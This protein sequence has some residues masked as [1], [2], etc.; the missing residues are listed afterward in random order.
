M[1][2]EDQVYWTAP[3]G[4]NA[5]FNFR[6][7]PSPLIVMLLL[8]VVPLIFRKSK[9]SM[10]KLVLPVVLF[11]TTSAFA[12]FEEG[13]ESFAAGDF[14]CVESEL[15]DPWPGGTAG[16]EW[17][18]PVSDDYSSEG[19]KSLKIE[20]A[21]VAGGPMDVIMNIGKTEGNWSLDWDMYVPEGNSAY[22]NV[23]GTDIA[24]ETTNSWQCNVLIYTDGSVIADGPWGVSELSYIPLGEWFN[25][26][27][28]VDLDQGIF[29]MWVDGEE[30]F[31]APYDGNFSSIN[32]YAL[33]DSETI[34]LYYL[35]NFTLA[36]SDVELVGV[37]D[38]AIVPFGFSP[39]PTSGT[40]NLSGVTASQNL[41]VLD[42]MGREV[43]RLPVEAGQKAVEVDLP[44]G[45]YLF[46][47][48]NG[49]SLR[50]L[51]VRR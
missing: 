33:G 10:K 5:P 48:E 25:I 22:L 15:F 51:V 6:M 7:L 39:N 31:Q 49:Q 16:S 30:L 11:A 12:Q 24:G 2:L 27:Y 44:D 13:F 37:E 43:S 36:E 8:C 28:V 19:E 34:G 23:Q 42:L 50:K 1:S 3:D 41:V 46:G 29:K 47:P 18:A 17:D 21:A 26:R 9:Q 40:L 38:V 20:A 35:D 14:I 45:V 32:F 4:V